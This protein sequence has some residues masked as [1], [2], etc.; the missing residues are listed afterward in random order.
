MRKVIFE[1]NSMEDILYWSKQDLK[2]VK[3]IFQLLD[4][5]LQTPF[6]GLGQPEHLKNRPDVWS[7]RINHEH[8]LVY[9]VTND[10]IIVLACRFHYDD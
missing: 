1:N 3:K 7:R 10:A 4:N 2:L 6:T 9:K 8:R 5:T